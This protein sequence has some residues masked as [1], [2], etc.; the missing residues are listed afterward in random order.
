MVIYCGNTYFRLEVRPTSYTTDNS[1]W[2]D[3][4]LIFIPIQEYHYFSIVLQHTHKHYQTYCVSF[5]ILYI[6]TLHVS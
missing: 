2:V 6:E 4:L 5:D 1:S 3:I